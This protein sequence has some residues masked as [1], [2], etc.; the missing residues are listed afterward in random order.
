[1]FSIRV[2]R[3]LLILRRVQAAGAGAEGNICLVWVA[4]DCVV[5]P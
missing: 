2:Q 3:E 1:M 4:G 5:C